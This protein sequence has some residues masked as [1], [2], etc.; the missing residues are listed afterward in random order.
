M[1]C[2]TVYVIRERGVVHL[3]VV[4]P[5]KGCSISN[6][7]LYIVT[8]SPCL[9]LFEHPRGV[10]KKKKIKATRT[11]VFSLLLCKPVLMQ[12]S[13]PGIFLV[14][15]KEARGRNDRW[16]VSHYLLSPRSTPRG[17]NPHLCI[18]LMEKLPRESFL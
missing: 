6:F 17:L 18:D 11:Y 8:G 14:I 10:K 16:A 13:S 1:I 9:R 5:K 4:S 7:F 2:D 15:Y 12:N 3:T